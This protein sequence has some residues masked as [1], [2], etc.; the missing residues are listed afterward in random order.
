MEIV[1]SI[2]DL[3][4]LSHAHNSFPIPPFFPP[5]ESA[6]CSRMLLVFDLAECVQRLLLRSRLRRQIR[7]PA[8]IRG[9]SVQPWPLLCN[10]SAVQPACFQTRKTTRWSRHTRKTC[11]GHFFECLT[12]P[13][14]VWSRCL[15]PGPS[16]HTCMWARLFVDGTPIRFLRSTVLLL[17]CF[18]FYHTRR[19]LQ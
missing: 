4:F 9:Q 14:G 16:L 10:G 18:F 1:P 8:K 12:F 3:M 11:Y 6:T 19:R 5:A 13:P 15:F 2:F 7:H 17:F